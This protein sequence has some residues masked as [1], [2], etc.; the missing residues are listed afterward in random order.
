MKTTIRTF[1]AIL[2]I[3]LAS[4]SSGWS[5]TAPQVPEEIERLH[6]IEGHFSGVGTYTAGGETIQVS[7]RSVNRR[8]AGGMGMEMLEQTEIPGRGT[9]ETVNLVGFDTETE[10][11]H[12]YSIMS[13]GTVHDH[14]GRWIDAQSFSVQYAGPLDGHAFTEV[15]PMTI[16]GPDAYRFSVV[17]LQDGVETMRFE[18]RMTRE[19]PSALRGEER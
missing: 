5:Q 11:L 4:A 19:E 13:D 17:V 2:T 16:E 18:V 6:Q 3:A 8:I 10:T 12:M 1:P 14:F 9:L 15:V 7:M